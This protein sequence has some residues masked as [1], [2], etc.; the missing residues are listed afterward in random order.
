M[1]R[2]RRSK[3]STSRMAASTLPNPP[4]GSFSRRERMKR[5]L[6]ATGPPRNGSL[7]M[8][9]SPAASR[10]AA[11][12]GSLAKS[13]SMVGS[14]LVC[15]SSWPSLS[16]TTKAA[17][18]GTCIR[19]SRSRC[20]MSAARGAVFSRA[21]SLSTASAASRVAAVCAAS[22]RVR[23]EKSRCARRSVFCRAA[24]ISQ[25]AEQTLMATSTTPRPTRARV[26]EM[27]LSAERSAGCIRLRDRGTDELGHRAQELGALDRLGE[28]AIRTGGERFLR[29]QAL[30]G[31]EMPRHSDERQPRVLAL[32]LVDRLDRAGTRHEHVGDHERRAL[33]SQLLD[34]GAAVGDLA[35][36]IARAFQ[37]V[38]HQ[39]AQDRIVVD[40]EDV[41][42]TAGR[43]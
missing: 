11:K 6:V 36:P 38:G 39:V 23:L 8:G 3:L 9:L 15:A 35:Y 26:S 1:V 5:Q 29:S 41:P 2:Y 32:E 27:R 13:G 37:P 10:C 7:R 25:M 20:S 21:T 12:K 18:C 42:G 34:P 43:T 17:I 4:P 40:D 22:S 16:S 31:V 19:S 28:G 24:R 33:A 14:S 30:A